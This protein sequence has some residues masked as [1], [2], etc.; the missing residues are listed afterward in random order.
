MDPAGV[1]PATSA[2]PI[3]RPVQQRAPF[4]DVA[5]GFAMIGVVVSNALAVVM[6]AEFADNDSTTASLAIEAIET[7]LVGGVNRTLLAMLLGIALVLT[8]H[9]AKQRG[10]SP[11]WLLARRYVALFLVFGVAHHAVFDDDILTHYSIAALVLTPALSWVVSGPRWRLLVLAAAL[12]PFAVALDALVEHLSSPPFKLEQLPRTLLAFMVGMWLA[13][14]T[15]IAGGKPETEGTRTN[16]GHA[17]RL[18]GWGLVAYLAGWMSALG[19]GPLMGDAF[20][21]DDLTPP[22]FVVATSVEFVAGAALLIGRAMVIFGVLWWLVDRGRGAAHL[23][24]VLAPIGRMSLSVYL[25]STTVFLLTLGRLTE[26]VPTLTQFGFGIGY[27]IAMA[28]LC[29]LW[30]G[31]FRY[32]PAEWLWRCLTHLRPL[33]LLRR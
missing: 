14:M 23:L 7:L 4:L 13:R 16:R 5:R 17:L 21:T 2:H 20:A 12:L 33:P 18:A 26:E 9:S 19:P 25:G 28:A 22:M 30:L 29:P 3:P 1:P 15:G 24:G 11:G 10:Q 32:G 6:S 8:W 27:A 31:A